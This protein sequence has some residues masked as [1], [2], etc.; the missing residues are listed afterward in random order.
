MD[1]ASLLK[2]K[3]ALHKKKY[4]LAIKLCNSSL[5]YIVA[6]KSINELKLAIIREKAINRDILSE[7]KSQQK[8]HLSVMPLMGDLENYAARVSVILDDEYKILRQ[9]SLLRASVKNISILVSKEH[10]IR[11][12]RDK[13]EILRHKLE[14]ERVA[15]ERF[16]D[17][18]N[19]HAVKLAAAIP[20][21]QDKY[22]EFSKSKKLL[23]EM[24]LLYGR[25]IYEANPQIAHR[26]ALQILDIINKL[27]NTELYTYMVSDFNYIQKRVILIMKNPKQ[28]KLAAALAGA[29]IIAPGTFELTFAFLIAKYA[30]KYAKKKFSKKRFFKKSSKK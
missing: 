1:L 15:S 17:S 7:L 9:I 8:K 20:E 22:K 28:N 16:I 4:Y 23:S 27:K 3:V 13:L 29:Y 18:V 6:Y 21:F 2:K 14:E 11:F 30:G 12:L 24:Q 10:S 25:M 26:E 19:S 5:Y